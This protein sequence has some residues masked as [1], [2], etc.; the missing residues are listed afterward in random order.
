MKT[1]A[2]AVPMSLLGGL[3]SRSRYAFAM[4]CATRVYPAYASFHVAM[5]R[6]DPRALGEIFDAMWQGV[7]GPGLGPRRL[8]QMLDACMALIPSEDDGW[9]GDVQAYAEDA[10]AAL[11]YAIRTAL[12]NGGADAHEAQYAG[13]RCFEAI[14]HLATER[15]DRE[16]ASG[17]PA[18]VQREVEQQLRDIKRLAEVDGSS[19]WVGRV[20]QLRAESIE[21]AGSF[22]AE[23]AAEEA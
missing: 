12:A 9:D 13:R 16:E 18:R 1:H 15:G 2:D 6:G 20:A 11:A 21:I 17:F 10:A 23:V 5:G 8:Q 14:D 22:A 7:L 3:S 4:L 19:A